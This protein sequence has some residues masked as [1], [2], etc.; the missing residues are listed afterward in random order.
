MDED[1]FYA[2]LRATPRQGDHT[3]TGRRQRELKSLARSSR[4]GAKRNV[5][6]N[7][8]VTAEVKA[9]VE[10]LAMT[11]KISLPDVIEHAVRAYAE[12]EQ[13]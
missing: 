5:Q 1:A 13:S 2:R 7:M 8:R 6:L 4:S 10:R 9:L 12:A 3:A 11:K